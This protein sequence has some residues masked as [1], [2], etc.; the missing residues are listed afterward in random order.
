MEL[1][2]LRYAVLLAETLHFGRAAERAYI[3]QPSFS[4]HIA[5]LERELGT[6]LFDRAS[7]RVQLTDAGR[8][9]VERAAALLTEMDAAAADVRALAEDARGALR[10]GVF[11]DGA[12]EITPL[13]LKAYRRLC[14]DVQ[15][16]FVE[17]SMTTQV[18]ALTSGRIDVAILRPPVPDVEL[19]LD[20]LFAEPR[21]AIL[22]ADHPLAERDDVSVQDLLD[23]PFVTAGAAA[24]AGWG[25]FWR[26]DV[27][28]GDAG[29]IVAEMSSVAEGL[30]SVAYLGAVDTCPAATARH[31]PHPGV[32]YVPL[33]DGGYT[34]VAIARRHGDDRAH[35]RAF[36]SGTIEITRRHMHVVPLA[37]PADT[38]P[39]GTPL[40]ARAA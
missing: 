34:S 9:L 16:S 17:L 7:N 1:R 19:D 40:P 22:A 31:Y 5:R 30:A 26:C 20:V 4:Q 35:V 10:V 3:S 6:Q 23:E 29:R 11:A 25:A 28:R 15:L 18:D 37:I 39:S 2:Q 33:R 36:A 38:A 27:A 12:G 14:P 13:L 32:A 8:L 21:V 24:P